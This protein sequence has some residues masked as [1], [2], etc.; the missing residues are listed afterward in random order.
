MKQARSTKSLGYSSP[1]IEKV[2]VRLL[3]HAPCH[4]GEGP[5]Y[6]HVSDTAWWF[7]IVEQTLFEAKLATG[8]VSS[9]VMP[10][11]A[12]ALAFVDEGTQLVVGEDGLYRRDVRSQ[13]M[14]RFASYSVSDIPMRSNDARVH[15]SG[16]LWFSIMGLQ[17]EVGAGSIYAFH[18]GTI[19]PLFRGITIPNAICFS[20]DG[21]TGYFAD[22]HRNLMMRVSL[23]PETGLPTADPV[24]FLRHQG[25]GWLDGA[26]T[27]VAGNIWCA[28]WGGSC[29]M[30]Y[31][32]F[33]KPMRRISVPALQPSCPVFVGTRLDTLLLTSASQD[34]DENARS[35][36]PNHGRTMLLSLKVEGKIEPRVRLA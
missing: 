21:S 33:G 18:H 27:D 31:S 12:S 2:A 1:S 29:V 3:D 13:S 11:M 30:A 25:E 22:S 24:P 20:P 19:R 35:N 28:H 16:T 9:H 15:P 34:M 5:N 32:P 36:D 17:A 10:V 8:A 14:T 23:D 6:D 7:D 4:L 26:V